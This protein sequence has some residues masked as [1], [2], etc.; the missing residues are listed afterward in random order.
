MGV[1]K[2]AGAALASVVAIT[3]LAS[4]E[5]PPPRVAIVVT[6]ATDG[7]DAVP[8]DG[9]CEMTTGSGDCSLRA[10]FA[11]SADRHTDVMVPPGEYLLTSADPGDADADLDVVG[12]IR[13][14]R[15]A[16][17]ELKI[18][19]R[20]GRALDVQAEGQLVANGLTI[21]S[22]VDHGAVRVSGVLVLGESLIGAIE[23][24]TTASVPTIL[25]EQGGEATL[26]NSR[27]VGILATAIHNRGSLVT[28]FASLDSIL[29][30]PLHTEGE[31][32]SVLAATK[33]TRSATFRGSVWETPG[34]PHCTGTAPV[35]AGYNR[36]LNTS[37]MLNQA[38]DVQT[39]AVFGLDRIPIGT[40]GCGEGY[41]IDVDGQPRPA[42]G[43]R[44]GLALC[45]IGAHELQ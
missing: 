21:E 7:P 27:V 8:G 18:E 43:D 12:D 6:T 40:L 9:V 16:P 30:P 5:P 3:A 23:L 14:A 13:L 35:S 1:R 42:D 45:D 20:A 11:E 39:D 36:A 29:A 31:G 22:D 17:G 4:C 44:D 19:S 41:A 34:E 33:L 37:C 32:R 24:P 28:L 15:S 2:A 38:T 26:S 25:I 10:A